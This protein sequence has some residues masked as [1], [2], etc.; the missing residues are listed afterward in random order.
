MVFVLN[1]PVGAQPGFGGVLKIREIGRRWREEGM[2]LAHLSIPVV[3][4][5][6]G[7]GR[8]FHLN[9]LRIDTIGQMLS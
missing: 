4:F 5:K 7:F 2:L 6:L 1:R 3:I 8:W 9:R